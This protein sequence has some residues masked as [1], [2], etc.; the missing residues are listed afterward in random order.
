MGNM[1]KSQLNKAKH[2]RLI[3]HFVA[4]AS[5][6]CLAD[7]VSV[8]SKTAVYYFHRLREIIAYHFEQDADTVFS[9]EIKVDENDFG[10]KRKVKRGQ[11]AAGKVRVFGLLKRGGKVY[12]K[13]ID[14]T[15][16]VILYPIIECKV[17]PDSIVYSDCWRSYNMSDVSEFKD[18][19]INGYN[20]KM[21]ML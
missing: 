13:V 21:C 18:S 20:L 1:R 6:R 2:D 3:E 11:G 15:S 8:N 17:V 7:L 12:M 16:S 4:G 14:D 10:G 19:R 5:A 9:G